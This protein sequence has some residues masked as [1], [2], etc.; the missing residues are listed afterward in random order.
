VE[1]I[2]ESFNLIKDG[3]LF[4]F[5]AQ[6]N[7]F[8]ATCKDLYGLHSIINSCCGYIN[9]K[10]IKLTV[11]EKEDYER[12]IQFYNLDLTILKR[13]NYGI[14]TN[15]WKNKGGIQSRYSWEKRLSVQKE[16]SLWLNKLYPELTRI[17]IR[18]NGIYDIRFRKIK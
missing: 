8:F 6:S 1:L 16:T 18:K 17:Q 7:K 3:G 11:Y 13:G 14:K 9:D 15:Y 2:E 12:C 5:S 4:G 10:R